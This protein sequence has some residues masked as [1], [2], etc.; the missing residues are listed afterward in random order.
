MGGLYLLNGVQ[1]LDIQL[2]VQEYI[3]KNNTLFGIIILIVYL[4]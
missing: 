2:L 4:E 1:Y 3:S